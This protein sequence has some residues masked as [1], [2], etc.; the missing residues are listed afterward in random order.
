MVV[1][2]IS[3]F[4]VQ[5]HVME[6][7]HR[8]MTNG[9]VLRGLLVGVVLAIVTLKVQSD[10]P[11]ALK[12]GRQPSSSFAGRLFPCM[13]SWIEMN[14]KNRVAVLHGP[15]WVLESSI[16]PECFPEREAVFT[17]QVG[18]GLVPRPFISKTRLWVTRGHDFTHIRIV[19]SSGSEE[20]DMVAV[21]FVTNHKCINRSS[22]GC[23]IKGGAVL[24]RID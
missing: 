15:D 6:L 4:G 11:L 23:S 8:A 9:V 18:R 21:G 20:Q 22:K 17:T 10:T 1:E 13:R 14:R 19:A 7:R 3:V 5:S 12:Q 16:R 2:L 24:I